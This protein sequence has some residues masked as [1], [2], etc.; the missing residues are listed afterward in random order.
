MSCWE[1]VL[2]VLLLLL[3]PTGCLLFGREAGVWKIDDFEDGDL[4]A[5]HGLFWLLIADDL[6]GGASEARLE[7]APGGTAGS[8]HALRL[9]G[10][11]RGGAGWPFA[12]AWVDLDGSGRSVDL[13]AFQGIR[14]RV[15]GPARLQIGLRTAMTNFMA[16]IEAGS[17]WK[18]VEVPFDSL[19][20]QGKVPEGT[21]WSPE[22]V[23]V[24]GVTT[25]QLPRG[26]ER[27]DGKVD[28][29]IDDV[30]LYGPGPEGA[31]PVAAG[32]EGRIS[33]V[34]FTPLAS[35]PSSGWVELA[36]DPAGDGKKPSLPDA[37]R[38]EAIPESPDGILWVRVTLREPPHD[39]WMGM[40]LAL[41]L[42]G[43]PTDGTAWWG[44]NGA[45]KFDQLVT[46]WCFHAGKGCEGYIGVSDAG[47]IASG[48][49]AAAGGNLKVA[50]DRERRAFVVGVP[51]SSLRLG[52][53][54]I[55]LVAAVGSALLYNDD[56]PGQGAAILH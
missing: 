49:Y 16:E 31:K 23:Q 37:T 10:R 41:D 13:R 19:Q 12:G 27:A 3:F 1:K 42:D 51:R 6:A 44:A 48:N 47:Q 46:V 8:K 25:P 21:R 50:I 18:T 38:L 39:R 54:D 34:P 40:N 53:G 2:L 22:A 4:R 5:P 14:L 55:R 11:L 7:I 9:T 17:A 56:V 32:S 45:F 20:P 24:F 15:K 35:I 52:K 28:F 36:V 29:E 26:E 30:T 43:D 33:N